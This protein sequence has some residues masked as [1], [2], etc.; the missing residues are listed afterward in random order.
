MIA[1]DYRRWGLDRL[2]ADQP[3]LQLCPVTDG[4][5]QLVG[6]FQFSAAADGAERIDDAYDVEFTIP[7]G[8]PRE[9]PTVRDRSGR[10]PRSHHTNP[11]GTLCLGSPTRQMMVLV[12]TPTLPAFAEKCLVP[13]L[14]GF[15]YRERHGRLPFGELDHGTAGLLRDF[16]ELFGASTPV[17]ARKFVGLAGLK[18]RLA[19]KQPCPCGSGRR[20][21]KCHNRRVNRLR[22]KLGRTWF[23]KEYDQLTPTSGRRKR[24]S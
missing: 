22:R 19:N 23:A 6:R 8:F 18:K 24:P 15:S 14:Y 17:A 20:L 21:G 5:L 13:Y 11:D 7:S 3:E 2:L 16:A 1:C 12:D 4:R 10:I 9:L